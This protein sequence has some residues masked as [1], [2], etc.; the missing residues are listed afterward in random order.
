MTDRGDAFHAVLAVSASDPFIAAVKKGLDGRAFV[1]FAQCRSAASARRRI[2]ERYYD[3][4]AINAPLP[5]EREADFVLDMAERGHASFLVVLPAEDY[6]GLSDRLMGHGILAL[7][8]P[9]PRGRIEKALRYLLSIQDR[10]HGLEKE[11]QKARENAEEIRVV[12]RAKLLLVEKQHM[13]E[14]EA[15][16]FIVKQAMDRRLQRK[17]VAE[18]I[19]EDLSDAF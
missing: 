4:I 18:R 12:S 8:K 3:V 15:H 7:S 19:L 17:R 16:R 5:D 13:T 2:L 6:A 1:S 11:I 9:L 10:M 14:E